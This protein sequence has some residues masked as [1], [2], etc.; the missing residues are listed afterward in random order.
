MSNN[1]AL[2]PLGDFQGNFVAAT[3]RNTFLDA[4]LVPDEVTP[5]RRQYRLLHDA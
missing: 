3:A 2:D 1:K 5:Y 4:H